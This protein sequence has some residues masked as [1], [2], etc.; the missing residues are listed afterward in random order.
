MRANANAPLTIAEIAD[1]A[2]C[3][4]RALQ[5]AFRQFRETTPM[6]VLQ[7]IRLEQARA[8]M[9]RSGNRSSLARIAEE[10]GFSSPSRFAQAF[11]RVYGIYP[12]QAI[13]T[14]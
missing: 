12:S 11:R 7:R 9:L 13:G 6:R 10:H 14:R 8:A 3:S 2:G 1:A 5:M 4:V